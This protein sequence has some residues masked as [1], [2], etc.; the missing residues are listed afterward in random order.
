MYYQYL[1]QHKYSIHVFWQSKLSQGNTNS[2]YLLALTDSRTSESDIANLMSQLSSYLS[3]MSHSAATAGSSEE[4]KRSESMLDDQ[5]GNI[6]RL[7]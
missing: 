4:N 6:V 3:Y 1:F 7:G 2:K 5:L